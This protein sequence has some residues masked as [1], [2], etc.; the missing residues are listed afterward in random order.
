MFGEEI[1]GT[2]VDSGRNGVA[3]FSFLTLA[4]YRR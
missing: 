1:A 3:S 4:L 2:E